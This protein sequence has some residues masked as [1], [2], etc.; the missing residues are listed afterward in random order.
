[1][2]IVVL[3][4]LAVFAGLALMFVVSDN[5]LGSTS[6]GIAIVSIFSFL[7]PL[8]TVV[9]GVVATVVGLIARKRV[10]EGRGNSSRTIGA[11]IVL[12]LVALPW[13][14]FWWKFLLEV[15]EAPP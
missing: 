12:G 3:L 11:G 5:D 4:G 14:I 9:G 1:M 8:A 15:M 13:G 10:K 2:L 7:F 6:L